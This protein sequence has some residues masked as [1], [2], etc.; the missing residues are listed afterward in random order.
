MNLTITLVGPNA[1]ITFGGKLQS[2]PSVTGPWTDVV[3]ATS[4]PFTT[5][6]SQLAQFYRAVLLN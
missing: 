6:A 3:A 1:V 4:S 5:P 2:A